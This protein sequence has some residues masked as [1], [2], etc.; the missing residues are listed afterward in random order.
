MANR[1]QITLLSL[2]IIALTACVQ[3]VNPIWQTYFS[4]SDNNNNIEW[5]NDLTLDN[6][7]D[8]L[9]TGSNITTGADRNEDALLAKYDQQGNL[10]WATKYDLPASTIES[11]SSDEK[12]IESV[13][14]LDGSIYSV[15]QRI[16]KIEGTSAKSSFVMKVDQDGNYLW[17]TKISDS[18]DAFDLEIA[19]NS[20]YVTGYATQRLSLAGEVELVIN[21]DDRAW[22]VEVDAL[23]NIYV[24]SKHAV[25]QYNA[26]GDLGWQ[27]KHSSTELSYRVNI[28]L[29]ESNDSLVLLQADAN[30]R[31]QLQSYSTQG[32]L[33]WN[34]SINLTAD[35]N[36][37]GIPAL[38][39]EDDSIW[40]A[41]SNGSQTKVGR[42]SNQGNTQ[43]TFSEQQGP[44]RDLGKLANGNIVI[45]GAGHSVLLDSQG[46]QLG[47][48]DSERSGSYTSGSL[49][50]DGNKMFVATSVSASTGISIH[51]AM[52]EQ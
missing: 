43:W 36:I 41:V 51:L 47:K 19:N 24:A 23:G 45:T 3:Q 37:A 8:L 46:K 35:Q 25:E 7:N 12:L 6:F 4:T 40:F 21:H 52:F 10:I 28:E 20:I 29:D 30:S 18:H 2:P 1:T 13:I 34:Q 48:N 22:D 33:N 42:V 17:A 15:G 32:E 38:I 5:L 27:V 11:T 49:V 31:F 44:I 9:L 26:E 14:D 16:E 39:V 50:V